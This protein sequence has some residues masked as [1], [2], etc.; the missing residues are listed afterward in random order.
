[1]PQAAHTHILSFSGSPS[2]SLSGHGAFRVYTALASRARA[3]YYSVPIKNQ[4][5]VGRL[6]GHSRGHSTRQ[7]ISPIE[8]DGAGKVESASLV[9][10]CASKNLGLATNRNR[11]P[12]QNIDA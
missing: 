12:L 4:F 10:K 2:F 3:D 1:M 6:G 5:G 11:C 7:I 9:W 8:M